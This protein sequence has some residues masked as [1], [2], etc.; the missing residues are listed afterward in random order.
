MCVYSYNCFRKKCDMPHRFLRDSHQSRNE[1]S[2]HFSNY[3]WCP[4]RI[5]EPKFMVGFKIKY[6]DECCPTNYS[7]ES[8]K[9]VTS[10]S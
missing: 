9:E 3:V 6:C 2:P 4:T 8:W 5:Q 10:T 7:E 1:I